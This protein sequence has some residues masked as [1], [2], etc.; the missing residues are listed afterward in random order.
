MKARITKLVLGILNGRFLNSTPCRYEFVGNIDAFSRE[1]LE[2]EERQRP[3][4]SVKK[5]LDEANQ[6]KMCP[7]NKNGLTVI[8]NG[9]MREGTIWDV[10][11]LNQ[12]L[13]SPKD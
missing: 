11:D 2:S 10:H 8:E 6:F 4:I 9:E 3:G 13:T 7:I 5:V 12:S 1:H